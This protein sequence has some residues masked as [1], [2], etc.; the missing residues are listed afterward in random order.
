MLLNLF[1]VRQAKKLART[2]EKE[3]ADRGVTLA[4]GQALDTLARLAGR[5]DWKEVV[6]SRRPEVLDQQLLSVELEHI[7]HSADNDYGEEA[8]LL[9]HTGF[10]LRYSA[11]EE[12][13]CDYVRVCDPAGREVAYW[14]SDEW[15]DD[16]EGVMGAI[17]GALARGEPLTVTGVDSRDA[18]TTS[19]PV[20]SSHRNLTAAAQAALEALC[21][22]SLNEGDTTSAAHEKVRQSARTARAAAQS[23]REALRS[24]QPLREPRI[25]DVRFTDLSAVV[26]D[27]NHWSVYFVESEMLGRLRDDAS[28]PHNATDGQSDDKALRDEDEVLVRL[29]D[30]SDPPYITERNLTVAFVRSLRWAA[31]SA[32]FVDAKGVTYDFVYAQRFIDA[33]AQQA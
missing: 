7:R 22:I 8:A 4:H 3:L 24:A 18:A 1:A 9:V 11:R 27:G 23:L 21:S 32:C 29:V 20:S 2:L 26:I 31:A 14:V 12:A 16:P 19:G 6:R 17:L 28:V 15:R 25:Q 30:E 33:W 5:R 13:P 10:S